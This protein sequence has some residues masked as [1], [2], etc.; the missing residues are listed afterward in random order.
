[1][2][3]DF[4]R[5]SALRFFAGFNLRQ[6]G[7][8]FEKIEARVCRPG[9]II[10]GSALTDPGFQFVI[11]GS[12]RIYVTVESQELTLTLLSVGDFFGEASVVEGEAPTALVRAEEP[13]LIY[14]LSR[15]AFMELVETN[16]TL[17]ARLWEALA[18]S[19]ITRMKNSNA[20]MRAYFGLNKAL[21]EN[22]KF[23]EFYQLCHFGSW[24]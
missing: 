21:C 22:P 10:I 8:I 6:L 13:T 19:L 17:A 5:F 3:P 4:K 11:E 14:F 9:Q 18:R 20:T 23:R 15:K 24:S 1:M 2:D 7:M 16:Q 12:V